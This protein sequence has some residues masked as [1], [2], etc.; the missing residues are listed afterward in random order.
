MMLAPVVS[1]FVKNCDVKNGMNISD[2]KFESPLPRRTDRFV[3]GVRLTPAVVQLQNNE[4][5][6]FAALMKVRASF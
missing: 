5:I 6:A 4:R 1:I 2:R 3:F